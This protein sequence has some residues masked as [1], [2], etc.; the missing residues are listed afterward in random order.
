M[1]DTIPRDPG[2]WTLDHA[3]SVFPA[4]QKANV[5]VG[6]AAGYM[7]GDHWQDGVP[8]MG[9]GRDDAGNL[10]TANNA[11]VLRHFVPVPECEGCVRERVNGACG[12]QADISAQPVEPVGKDADGQPAA[13]DA[14][15][16]EA[17]QW[18]R[19]VSAWW[20]R[21]NLWGG[22]DIYHPTGVR[23]VVTHASSH[24]N[25]SACLRAF[26]NPASLRDA[27][28]GSRQIPRQPDRRSALRHIEVT[29]P[30]P[31]RCAVYTDP[32][33]LQ[34]TGVFLYREGEQDYAEIWFAR[35]K[36]GRQVTVWRRLASDGT[37]EED[38][39]YPW[40]G[41]LPIVQ[42]DIGT[43]LTE[44][45]RRLQAVIDFD[46]TG[47]KRNTELHSFTAR[48]EINAAP[49]G[50][51]RLVAPAGIEVPA[52]KTLADGRTVFFWADTPELGAVIRNLNGFEYT[53]SI[54]P[55]TGKESTGVTTPAVH[56]HEPSSPD[57]LI[58][59][60]DTDIMLF[61][62]ACHQG[63]RV[64]GLLGSTAEASGDAYEQK[65]AAFEADVK[66]V[67]EAVDAPLAQFL[68]VVTLMA[69]YLTGKDTPDFLDEW[70]VV[71]QSHPS[72]GPVSSAQQQTAVALVAAEI[73]S[74]EEATARVGVQ[75]VQRER[76][77][78]Q[79]E[80]TPKQKG[81]EA[82]ALIDAG[83]NPVTAW[84]L[85]GFSDEEARDL[86]RTDGEPFVN[87]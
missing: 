65:R 38:R 60:L 37:A 24:P 76:D 3:R 35:A 11:R 26:F 46:A 84:T 48:T 57:A 49:T 42:C 63:H 40:G 81:E 4:P 55:E 87:Q 82:K 33:T 69:D 25:G 12:N 74:K 79:A 54:D 19:D 1:T 9:P 51:W 72:A 86:A 36:G 61:R 18:K 21:T 41:R 67:A 80:R 29:A 43:L 20:D 16:K 17:Q 5:G 22:V 8:W 32:D 56:Y 59:A 47:K 45:V 39:E 23:G 62:E 13:N 73:I 7:S 15:L 77:R 2:T 53:S 58:K 66:S 75:D 31:D 30:S 44:P 34:K 71:A 14:R 64:T 52:T 70:N 83:G 85:G 50:T 68:T 28:D 10:S 6:T 78:I 27:T